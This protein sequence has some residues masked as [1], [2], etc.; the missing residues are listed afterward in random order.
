MYEVGSEKGKYYS[1]NVPLKDGID[2]QSQLNIMACF[3]FLINSFL[4][5][6]PLSLPASLSPPPLSPFPSPSPLSPQSLS[7]PPPL[8]LPS[9]S[10]SLPSPS[11]SP[12]PLSGYTVVFRPVVQ[13]VIDHYRPSCIVLQVSLPSH[14]PLSLSLTSSISVELIH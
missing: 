13:S 12:L 7:L 6:L 3:V 8:F 4:P 1:L 10:L 11:L 5:Y 14:I 9:L 2:D